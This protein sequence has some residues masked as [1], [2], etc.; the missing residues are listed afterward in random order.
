MSNILLTGAHS[1]IINKNSKQKIIDKLEEYNFQTPVDLALRNLIYKDEITAYSLFPFIS[2]HRYLESTI[3]R[4][5]TE[6]P[7]EF[8]SIT[9]RG[10]YRDFSALDTKSII[11]NYAKK[12]GFKISPMTNLSSTL[13]QILLMKDFI[14]DK[15]RYKGRLH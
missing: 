13:N 14:A 12:E 10:F 11:I 8:E 4:Q 9:Q 1:Y 5:H 3:Q 15:Y 6:F 7:M 2:T